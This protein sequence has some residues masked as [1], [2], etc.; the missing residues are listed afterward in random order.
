MLTQLQGWSIQR[1]PRERLGQADGA[2][3]QVHV[4]Q[5]VSNHL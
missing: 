3:R 5:Y 4:L 2:E 1:L